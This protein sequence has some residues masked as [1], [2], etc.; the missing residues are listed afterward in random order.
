MA[1]LSCFR[2]GDNENLSQASIH[3]DGDAGDIK[4]LGAEIALKTFLSQ[5]LISPSPVPILVIGE[6]GHL[7]P[8][9]KPYDKRVVGVVS[10]AGGHNPGIVLNKQLA[11]SNIAP[12]SRRGRPFAK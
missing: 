2:G 12:R 1:I 6:D 8:S 7:V 4:L 11:G 5:G 3:L 9:S 10:G